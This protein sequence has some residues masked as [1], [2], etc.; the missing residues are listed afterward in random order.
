MHDGKCYVRSAPKPRS[1]SIP[2]WPIDLLSS[3]Y[4]EFVLTNNLVMNRTENS[5]FSASCAYNIKITLPYFRA[6]VFARLCRM[7]CWRVKLLT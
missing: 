1:R 4:R 5:N 3:H 6:G 7:V 2:S